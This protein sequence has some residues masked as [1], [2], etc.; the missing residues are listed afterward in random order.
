M[1]DQPL[2][3]GQSQ[4]YSPHL[5]HGNSDLRYLSWGSAES[6]CWEAFISTRKISPQLR[7]SISSQ[8]DPPTLI[9]QF[10]AENLS[11]NPRP[12]FGHSNSIF[13]SPLNDQTK[14]SWAIHQRLYSLPFQA[15]S[16]TGRLNA[17]GLLQCL[18]G[19]LSGV[20]QVLLKLS[21]NYNDVVPFLFY[22]NPF[23]AT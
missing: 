12:H 2:V 22:G 3:D 4:L 8:W 5:P 17:H 9:E 11:F 6:C 19:P 14:Q 21:G 23:L 1:E 18:V 7:H 13:I 15:D 16:E 20:D 10:P